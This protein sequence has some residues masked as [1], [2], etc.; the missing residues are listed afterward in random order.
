MRHN[1]D[2]H[3]E[4]NDSEE[5]MKPVSPSIFFPEPQE[6]QPQVVE[7][8]SVRPFETP[9]FKGSNRFYPF[10]CFTGTYEDGN[11]KKD[12]TFETQLFDPSIGFRVSVKWGC[13]GLVSP[14]SFYESSSKTLTH[15][16]GCETS[17]EVEI[18]KRVSGY[19][20]LPV[21]GVR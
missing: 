6:L 7:Y 18:R 17:Y 19:H 21:G 10:P 1:F 15:V 16:N 13:S 14:D 4:P 9:C 8:N 20:F 5:E 2:D 3:P 12:T 11:Q